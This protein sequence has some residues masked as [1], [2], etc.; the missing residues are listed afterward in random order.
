MGADDV[1]ADIAFAFLADQPTTGL[2]VVK[3]D[4]LAGVGL[5]AAKDNR[6]KQ[7]AGDGYVFEFDVSDVDPRLGLAGSFGI[8]GI[9]HAAWSAFVWLFLL[10]RAEIKRPPYG[11]M[12]GDVLIKDVIDDPIPIFSGIGLNVY[13]FEGLLHVCIPKGDVPDTVYLWIRRDSSNSQANT[14]TDRYVL[15]EHVLCAVG[16]AIA[17]PMS[18]FRDDDIIVI[19]AGDV[20]DMEISAT[21]IDAVG[22]E[23]KHRHC[24]DQVETFENSQLSSGVD[25][26]VDVVNDDIQGLADLYVKARRVLDH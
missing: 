8:E 14:Q 23:R 20:V 17:V 16:V 12:H 18:G 3:H 26:D 22:V 4:V 6:E 5:I 25:L 9:Q 7:A 10:L 2:H 19:L 21:W 13:P 15:D 1:F 11:L 24:T